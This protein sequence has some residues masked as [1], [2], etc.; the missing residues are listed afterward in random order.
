MDDAIHKYR[1]LSKKV[2]TSTSNDLKATFDYTILKQE[3]KNII[4]NA[5][6]ESQ[7]LSTELKDFYSKIYCTLFNEL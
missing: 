6:E 7:S 5:V 2:F 3:I 4:S 1:T